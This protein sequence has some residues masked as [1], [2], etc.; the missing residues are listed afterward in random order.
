MP[1]HSTIEASA[2]RSGTYDL[3]AVPD[4]GLSMWLTNP[5]FVHSTYLNMVFAANTSL[6]LK[7]AES[8]ELQVVENYFTSIHRWLPVIHPQTVQRRLSGFHTVET[9]A[10]MSL[11]VLTMHLVTCVPQPPNAV[12]SDQ[13]ES[14]TRK[15]P[16][17][18]PSRTPIYLTCKHQ[19]AV[20]QSVGELSLKLIQC[21]FLIALYE[22]GQGLL[23][24][25]Y[26]TLGSCASMASLLGFGKHV[27]GKLSSS[28]QSP[29]MGCSSARTREEQLRMWWGL[30]ILDR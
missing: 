5:K 8:S 2:E 23:E 16:K 22:Y 3:D 12:P 11:L 21:G 18:D 26:L 15:K 17:V 29:T 1:T 10:S 14:S 20:L 27:S 25:S 6:M 13:P 24:G 9:D 4:F 30:A 28:S 19:F 7:E